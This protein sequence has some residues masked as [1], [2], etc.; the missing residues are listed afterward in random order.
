MALDDQHCAEL[1]PANLVEADVNDQLQRAHQIESAPN[2]QA[3]LRA[4][5]R[6]QPVDRAVVAP[7]ASSSGASGH[8]PGS[9]SS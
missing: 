2:K 5:G 4:L 1:V 6:V 3:F 8:R 7:I 9:H